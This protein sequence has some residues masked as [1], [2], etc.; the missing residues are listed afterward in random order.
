[1]HL[2]ISTLIP[3]YKVI[4]A[5]FSGS[6]DD[7]D[8]RKGWRPLHSAVRNSRLGVQLMN[9]EYRNVHFS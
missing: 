9:K 7:D 1:M 8:E 4:K 3:E 6:G 5:Q 2:Q